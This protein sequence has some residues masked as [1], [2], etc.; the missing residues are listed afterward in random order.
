MPS[1]LDHR[2]RTKPGPFKMF[3]GVHG[4]LVD[5]RRPARRNTHTPPKSHETA[6]SSI[7]GTGF[8]RH[9]W[10]SLQVTYWC[11]SSEDTRQRRGTWR[12]DCGAAPGPS[13]ISEGRRLR[14][15]QSAL[16]MPRNTE[17][18]VSALAVRKP[19]GTN[20]LLDDPRGRWPGPYP[21]RFLEA[22]GSGEFR[23]TYCKHPPH[24]GETGPTCTYFDT[25]PP[26]PFSSVCS[27]VGPPARRTK[28]AERGSGGVHAPAT[29][30]PPH[31]LNLLPNDEPSPGHF[32]AGRLVRRGVCR[33]KLLKTSLP[34][35]LLAGVGGI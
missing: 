26:Q 7:H 27:V 32:E 3:V 15:I 5:G 19:Q 28:W 8:A 10:S 29:P 11:Q 22:G 13:A 1:W 25:T 6:E 34:N 12:G 31:S 24:R 23:V 18:M 21:R 17:R 33:H 30:S 2:Y 16:A 35:V 14:R 4:C 9:R 20:T